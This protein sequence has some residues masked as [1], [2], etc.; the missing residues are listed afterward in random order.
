[1]LGEDRPRALSSCRGRRV[2][3]HGVVQRGEEWGQDDHE[4]QEKAGWQ[5]HE[6]P[7]ADERA[8]GGAVGRAVRHFGPVN[9]E[10]TIDGC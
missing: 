6:N 7:W 2:H 8:A 9:S 1:M 3:G 10:V 5:V 4:E